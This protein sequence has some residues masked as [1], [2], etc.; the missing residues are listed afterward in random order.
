MSQEYR[1]LDATLSLINGCRIVV[2][3]WAYRLRLGYVLY[4]GL[5]T[6]RGM[7]NAKPYWTNVLIHSKGMLFMPPSTRVHYLSG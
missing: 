6:L 5:V 1:G 7:Q 2:S 4:Q 3:I